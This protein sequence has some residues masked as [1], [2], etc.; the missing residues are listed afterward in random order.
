M[1]FLEARFAI[2]VE[3]DVRGRGKRLNK[4]VTLALAIVPVRKVSGNRVEEG[5][6]GGTVQKDGFHGKMWKRRKPSDSL[7]LS[8]M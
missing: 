5:A 1:I 2:G 6:V 3:S 8:Q 4:K 7:S